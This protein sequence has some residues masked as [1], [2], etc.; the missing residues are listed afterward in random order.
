MTEKKDERGEKPQTSKTISKY[1]IS[2]IQDL[3]LKVIGST[4][5]NNCDGKK[6]EKLLRQNHHLWHSVFMPS[7]QL[8]PLRDMEYDVWSADTLF[9]LVREGQETE[10]EK[11]VKR[12]LHADEINWIGSDKRM[13]LLGHWKKDEVYNPK[14]I[15][16]VWWD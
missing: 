3:Q 8:Y 15:L 9:V 4:T 7:S 6:I 11:L 1:K 2:K 12:Q 16:S 13:E 14:L 10:L 5:H